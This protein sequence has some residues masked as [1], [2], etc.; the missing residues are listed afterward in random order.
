MV[1]NTALSQTTSNN[2]S[3]NKIKTPTEPG[4]SLEK[5]R[6]YGLI[7]ELSRFS[8][9]NNFKYNVLMNIT[10]YPIIMFNGNASKLVIIV[11]VQKSTRSGTSI[12]TTSVTDL[13]DSSVNP[14]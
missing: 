2:L 10:L 6:Y 8:D 1:I 4:A 12:S 3:K 13:A 7:D 11:V 14:R 9:Y 5:A